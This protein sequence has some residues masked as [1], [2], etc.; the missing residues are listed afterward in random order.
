MNRSRQALFGCKDFIDLQQ[1]ITIP[2]DLDENIYKCRV[3]Y[4][5]I[6]HEI[7]FLPYQIKPIH[8]LHLVEANHINYSHKYLDRSSFA[9]LLHAAPA[10]DILIVKNGLI[11][12]TS[13]ANVVFW[14][15]KRWLTPATPLLPGTKRQYLLD[16]KQIECDRLRPADLHR[17][18]HARLINAMLDLDAGPIISTKNI[19]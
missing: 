14:D 12:D 17:F 7:E 18:T 8:T 5:I 9:P 4:D 13:Y 19:F 1:I 16:I 15:G 11:T 3:V 2:D 10:D 6:I